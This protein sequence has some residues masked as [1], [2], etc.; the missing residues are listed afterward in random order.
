MSVIFCFLQAFISKK[1]G[2]DSGEIFKFSKDDVESYDITRVEKKINYAALRKGSLRETRFVIGKIIFETMKG[3]IVRES[4]NKEVIDDVSKEKEMYDLV[5]REEHPMGNKEKNRNS[6]LSVLVANAVHES[7]KIHS[8]MEHNKLEE[9]K[10]IITKKRRGVEI[11]EC[12]E[13][14]KNKYQEELVPKK[15]KP[16]QQVEKKKKEVVPEAKPKPEQAIRTE[17]GEKEKYKQKLL[18]EKNKGSM[19]SQQVKKKKE[20]APE[21]KREQAIRT[22]V[23]EE[24][25]KYK[26]KVVNE[27]N[28]VHVLSRLFR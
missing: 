13:G 1:V 15:S 21:V 25:E 10:A 12:N 9:H 27:K 17:I 24:K 8:T 11:Q 19:L 16:S 5:E 2:E 22:Q 3:G 20:A 26:Q 28:N 18:T 6:H 7:G 4:Q 14:V 23:V